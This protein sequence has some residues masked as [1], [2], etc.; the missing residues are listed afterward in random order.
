M[1]IHTHKCGPVFGEACGRS[2]LADARLIAALAVLAALL[3][4]GCGMEDKQKALYKLPKNQRVLVFVDV[5]PTVVA[6]AG[7]ATQVA[8]KVGVELFRYK[9]LEHTVAPGRLNELRRNQE[10]FNKMGVADIARATD[11][12]VVICVD[13]VTFSASTLSDKS[14][15]QGFAQAMVKVIDSHGKRLWPGDGSAGKEIDERVDPA[16]ADQ[17]DQDAVAKELGDKL[18]RDVARLFHDYD[19]S[20]SELMKAPGG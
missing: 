13:L 2:G 8:E 5:H 16:F 12:D 10:A 3:L 6:P 9:A 19:Q 11:A 7:F 18:A 17:R 20:E 15:T 4:A 14:V 1:S